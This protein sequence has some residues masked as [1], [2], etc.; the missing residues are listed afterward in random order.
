VTAKEDRPLT[1]GTRWFVGLR[2][3]PRETVV[4]KW[5]ANRAMGTTT[6]VGSSRRSVGGR[7]YL[8][9]SRLVFA[10]HWCAWLYGARPWEVDLNNVREVGVAPASWA[11]SRDGSLRTRLQLGTVNRAGHRAEHLFTV[12]RP[13]RVAALIGEAAREWTGQ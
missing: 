4:Q 6:A 11:S 1:I 13:L 12:H 9:S 3:L 8:T 7:L 10:P 2:A 5:F